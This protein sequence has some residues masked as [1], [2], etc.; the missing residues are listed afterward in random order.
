MS[1]VIEGEGGGAAT[2]PSDEVTDPQALR[3]LGFV[4]MLI[5]KMEMDADGQIM[6]TK[7]TGK[8]LG[9]CDK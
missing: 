3:A 2:P 9:D 6:T 1:D 5:E 4:Q 8:R 7:Y